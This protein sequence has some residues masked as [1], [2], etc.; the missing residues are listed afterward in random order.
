MLPFLNNIDVEPDS[1]VRLVTAQLLVDLIVICSST[2]C[3][4]IL[5]ILHK[6]CVQFTYLVFF[7]IKAI[8]KSNFHDRFHSQV[9]P[10]ERRLCGAAEDFPYCCGCSVL[11]C[12]F[13]AV[14]DAQY[15]GGCS[16]LQRMFNTVEDV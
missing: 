1:N 3:M 16:V 12:M 14:E 4:D 2:K 8:S 10:K 5:A 9:H 15:C 11:L 6:V 13:S 7:S